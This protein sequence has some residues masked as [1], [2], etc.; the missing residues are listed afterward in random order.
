M[1]SKTSKRASNCPQKPVPQRPWVERPRFLSEYET[2]E[3]DEPLTESERLDRMLDE[4]WI[5]E[6]WSDEFFD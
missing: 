2:P 6:D 4:D 5:P 1:N 3:P